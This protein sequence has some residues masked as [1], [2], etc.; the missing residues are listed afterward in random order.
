MIIELF[1]LPGAGK[2]TCGNNIEKKFKIKNILEFYREN[3]IGKILF[4]LFLYCFLLNANLREKYTKILNILQKEKIENNII[5]PHIKIELYI[6]YLLFAYCIEYKSK[7]SLVIDEGIIHYCMALFAE[8][9]VSIDIL[10]AIIDLLKISNKKIIIISLK[11][12]INKAIKQMQI[13]KRKRTSLD[14]LSDEKLKIVLD[15]YSVVQ[16]YF[17]K[18]YINLDIIQIENLIEREKMNEI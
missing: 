10:E 5:N 15:R 9:N 12:P 16:K 3:L 4:H 14:F 6:K 8:F 18:K 17:S 13:R 2:T 7:K 11:C 1:G